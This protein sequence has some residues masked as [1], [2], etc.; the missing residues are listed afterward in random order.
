MVGSI[1]IRRT[2]SVDVM[3]MVSNRPELV[4]TVWLREDS[5]HWSKTGSLVE[6]LL[7]LYSQ[8]EVEGRGKVDISNRYC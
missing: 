6:F 4:S 5:C 8:P 7:Y 1:N 3:G 2:G